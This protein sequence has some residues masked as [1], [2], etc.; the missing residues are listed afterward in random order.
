MFLADGNAILQ[1][2]GLCGEE[3]LK[4]VEFEFKYVDFASGRQIVLAPFVERCPLSF[5]LPLPL[6]QKSGDCILSLGSI[7]GLSTLFNW[8]MLLAFASPTLS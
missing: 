1:D 6:C 7:S 8:S 2:M 3:I 5:D 4:D